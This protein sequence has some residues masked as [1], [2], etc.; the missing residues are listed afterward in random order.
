MGKLKSYEHMKG[1]Q[2]FRLRK[3]EGGI[4][5]KGKVS[6]KKGLN[7]ENCDILKRASNSL[8]KKYKEDEEIKCGFKKGF[9]HT[10]EWKIKQGERM[11]NGGALKARF[12]KRKRG[13]TKIE[14][15]MEKYLN[16]IGI[17]NIK[18]HKIDNFEIDFFIPSVNLTIECDG[19]YWHDYPNHTE[20]DIERDYYLMRK[21]LFG[22]RF[23][24][25]EIKNENF[26][27]N[28]IINT[29][30]DIKSRGCIC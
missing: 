7:K 5:N 10:E 28:M 14:I 2:F 30:N 22:L 17:D 1:N 21:G 19:E 4:K 18:K 8:K 24:G 20:K 16:E 25:K 6:P 13:D 15:C 9:K 29:I 12:S 26:C 11:K 27:K 3:I 23:W